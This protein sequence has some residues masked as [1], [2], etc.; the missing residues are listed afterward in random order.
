M[1]E[2]QALFAVLLLTAAAASLGS[3]TARTFPKSLLSGERLAMQILAGFGLFALVLFLLSLWRLSLWT[4]AG[5]PALAFVPAFMS[6]LPRPSLAD[7][8][9]R[10]ASLAR[11]WQYGLIAIILLVR[12]VSAFD[13]PR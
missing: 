7:L 1:P 3:L 13:L 11:R 9:S 12:L 6:P 8:R 10:C 4:V 5:L 2:L